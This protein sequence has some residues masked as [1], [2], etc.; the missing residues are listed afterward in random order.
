MLVALV[1]PGR[2][3]EVFR[4][5]GRDAPAHP[6]PNAG[7]A[8]AAVAAA[9]GVQLGGPLRYGDQ[10]DVR[11]QLGDGPRP[12]PADIGRAIRLVDDVE[13]ALFGMLVVCAVS[14]AF[15]GRST[16]RAGRGPSGAGRRS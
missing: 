2:A 5:V 9:L 8:E 11:P 1:R 14:L 7:V 13:R 4:V 15:A 16:G 6:S 3:R 12:A 10:V